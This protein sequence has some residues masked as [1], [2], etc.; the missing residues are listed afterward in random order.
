VTEQEQGKHGLGQT[1]SPTIAELFESL[2][3]G[4]EE[5]RIENRRARSEY[6]IRYRRI[7]LGG[8]AGG[9]VLTVSI[10]A[11]LVGRDRDGLIPWPLTFTAISFLVAVVIGAIIAHMEREE[12]VTENAL[13]LMEAAQRYL[14]LKG[15]PEALEAARGFDETIS[16]LEERRP[17]IQFLENAM[18]F[19]LLLGVGVS[20]IVLIHFTVFP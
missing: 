18:T 3:V 1:N 19:F 14:K 15:T 13:G 4:H 5:T 16:N 11:A 2:A 8:A 20:I 9:L 7:L 17:H 10:C 6:Q 12:M